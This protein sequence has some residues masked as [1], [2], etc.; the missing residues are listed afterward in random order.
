MVKRSIS[1]LVAIVLCFAFL[2]GPV[3]AAE[4]VT[5]IHI[6]GL[7]RYYPA[8]SA[9]SIS[10]LAART[11]QNSVIPESAFSVAGIEPVS[12]TWELGT[13]YY[14][15]FKIAPNPSDFDF[16][17]DPDM[18]T[19]YVDTPDAGTVLVKRQE[20][21]SEEYF[22]I[23]P[24]TNT[25]TVRW[26]VVSCLDPAIT[27]VASLTETQA[28]IGGTVRLTGTVDP[29]A[30]YQLHQAYVKHGTS[31]TLVSVSGGT[32]NYEVKA[33]DVGDYDLVLTVTILGSDPGFLSEDAVVKLAGGAEITPDSKEL[34]VDQKTLILTFENYLTLTD[35][36]PDAS[37]TYTS[38]NTTQHSYTCAVCGATV[39]ED[40][41]F[42]TAMGYTLSGHN[43][44]CDLCGGAG[45]L[46]AHTLVPCYDDE[47][48]WEECTGCDYETPIPHT[49]HEFEQN[50]DAAGHWDACKDCDYKTAVTAHTLER[51]YDASG[52][53]EACKDCDH[54]TTPIAHILSI[55]YDASGHW[56]ECDDCDY[57][58]TPE[59][60]TW[61][62]GTVNKEATVDEE[63]EMTYTCTYCGETKVEPIAKLALS[64]GGGGGGSQIA[65]SEVPLTGAPDGYSWEDRADFTEEEAA[66]YEELAGNG[67]DSSVLEDEDIW[68]LPET[69]PV[70]PHNYDLDYALEVLDKGILYLAGEGTADIAEQNFS[71]EAFYAV[72]IGPGDKAID[73]ANLKV[74]DR[75]RTTTFNGVYV[76]SVPKAG[77]ASHD[78]DVIAAKD[79]VLAVYRAF[80]LDNPGVFWLTGDAKVRVLTTKGD[81]AASYLFLVLADDKGYSMRSP[82]YAAK[83][84]IS[85]GIQTREAQ[86][87]QIVQSFPAS[88]VRTVVAAINRWLTLHNEYNRSAD[89]TKIGNRPRQGITALTGAEG[90]NGPVC[91]GYSKAFKIICDKLS[92][93]CVLTT[94]VA[95]QPNGHSE[96]HMWNQV[97]IDGVWYGVDCAWNDP[98]Y[99]G[100]Y[101]AL[102]GR[103][104][105][106]YLLVG[107]D[108]LIEGVPF[109]TSHKAEAA[110]AGENVIYFAN[111]LLEAEDD[112]SRL[113]YHDVSLSD[114][115]Y[116]YVKTAKTKD[117]MGGTSTE[118][119]S[120]QLTATRGQIVQILYNAAGQPAVDTVTVDGWYGKAA[121]WAI[122]KG[123]MTGYADG[124]FHGSDPV[125]REQLATILWAY[126]SAPA[127]EG[128]LNYADA[129]K[130]H[131]YAKA[132][133]LWARAE[134]ILSGK[135][136]NLA[137]PQGT[138]TRA[139]IATVFANYMK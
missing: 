54:A 19:V 52:H 57:A 66:F 134:G 44:M 72:G 73:F 15:T 69:D 30:G 32:A 109:K 130:V 56:Q 95:T 86:A 35:H 85:S 16:D 58:T 21:Y 9:A 2:P 123:Y 38:I 78:K 55:A 112:E 135:P 1:I 64:G 22:E 114:W 62:A 28:H 23:D 101:G 94:G 126:A 12:M 89:L 82:E 91:S 41:V 99:E 36:T 46:E 14:V 24:D 51:H 88:D 136:G 119:F 76:M 83:G 100:I 87:N 131:D 31:N 67:D 4:A 59:T 98:V 80:E 27:N 125:T 124:F 17:D 127:Q 20:T 96:Y 42:T 65:N 118:R 84:S 11:S 117:L 79:A 26:R 49:P 29:S 139:E 68:V 5:N 25:L 45:E 70:P 120:P 50:F 39:T 108:T 103:E 107:D 48:H 6:S 138:A 33:A 104:N 34:S 132:A 40:H 105:E 43:H 102:S 74:G 113:A 71:D 110:P 115:F 10:G 106:R 77:N 75:V 133:L 111:L 128:Q 129:A 92:I 47:G 121:S 8:G 122:E 53:W 18:L 3:H 60:H 61:D 116:P 7:E 63:G 37:T 137:D 97:R 13:T 90:T 93:P 81:N